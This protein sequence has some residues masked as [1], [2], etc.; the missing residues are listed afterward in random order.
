MEPLYLYEVVSWYKH[1][2]QHSTYEISVSNTLLHR[3]PQGRSV[4]C[5]RSLASQAGL[6][7]QRPAIIQEHAH[8]IYHLSIKY[9]MMRV[10]I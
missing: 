1:L 5:R 7:R 10:Q 9:N 3:L 4:P 8:G 6:G 2:L